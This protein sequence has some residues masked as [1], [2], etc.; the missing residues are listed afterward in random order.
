MLVVSGL[1]AALAGTVIAA[2]AALRPSAQGQGQGQVRAV[3]RHPVG[4]P[5]AELVVV[6]EGLAHAAVR[7]GGGRQRLEAYRTGDGERVWRTDIGTRPPKITTERPG[8]PPDRLR[9]GRGAAP[10]EQPGRGVASRAC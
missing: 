4:G 3:W 9:R 6:S 5:T 10:A 8:R 1:A 2:M 7:L